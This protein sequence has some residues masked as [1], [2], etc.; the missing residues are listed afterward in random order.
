MS[1][2]TNLVY[3]ILVS[4]NMTYTGPLWFARTNGMWNAVDLVE[5]YAGCY[6]RAEATRFGDYLGPTIETQTV[7]EAQWTPHASLTW[8]EYLSDGTRRTNALYMPDGYTTGS[9]IRTNRID[10]YEY[11]TAGTRYDGPYAILGQYWTT[12][13]ANRTTNRYIRG[14]WEYYDVTGTTAAINGRYRWTNRVTRAVDVE[15]YGGTFYSYTHPVTFDAYQKVGTSKQLIDCG[16]F[17]GRKHFHDVDSALPYYDFRRGG[18]WE[19]LLDTFYVASSGYFFNPEYGITTAAHWQGLPWLPGSWLNDSFQGPWDVNSLTN[20]LATPG[21]LQTNL[22]RTAYILDPVLRREQLVVQPIGHYR[23][24][25]TIVYGST[26]HLF[27]D[28]TWHG[29]DDHHPWLDMTLT[30]ASGAFTFSDS[31]D[32]MTNKTLDFEA[33]WI[34][35]DLGQTNAAG[36]VRFDCQNTNW[37]EYG[38]IQRRVVTTNDYRQVHEA[39]RM[40]DRTYALDDALAWVGVASNSY[41]WSGDGTNWA[42]AKAACAAATPTITTANSA[43]RHG[44]RGYIAGVSPLRYYATAWSRKAKLTVSQT[45]EI[46]AQVDWYLAATN[47][48]GGTNGVFFADTLTLTGGGILNLAS[49]GSTHQA[50]SITSDWFG[51]TTFPNEWCAEPV[52][53]GAYDG[54]TS[55][56]DPPS[57]G[58][59]IIDENAVRD[60]LFLYCTNSI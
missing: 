22:L 8:F 48:I 21:P 24:M 58:Y 54:N 37:S 7:Y 13:Y 9:E 33:E 35:R 11:H 19:V 46:A 56:D 3:G 43:P 44:T 27:R 26:E 23:V 34:A 59:V 28:P 53:N 41:E 6:E 60:W 20:V 16:P 25:D 55:D 42:E 47:I 40:L 31:T 14:A 5:L 45:P 29:S 15:G 18:A 38:H 50:A 57:K 1:P 36:R 17:G 10:A 12:S 30:N 2:F 51:V 49:N 39:L 52:T 32:G 4:T